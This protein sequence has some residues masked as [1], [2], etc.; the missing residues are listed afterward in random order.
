MCQDPHRRCR[1]VDLCG[2]RWAQRRPHRVPTPDPVGRS[3]P[4]SGR[5]AQGRGFGPPPHAL[6]STKLLPRP[7]PL[8]CPFSAIA[9]RKCY[10]DLESSTIRR[11]RTAT[12]CPRRFGGIQLVDDEQVDSTPAQRWCGDGPARS[13]PVHLTLRRP[14]RQEPRSRMWN[15]CRIPASRGVRRARPVPVGSERRRAA[16][17]VRRC[18]GQRLGSVRS[19]LCGRGV[20]RTAMAHRQARRARIPVLMPRPCR[21][22]GCARITGIA[23]PNPRPCRAACDGPR[24][25]P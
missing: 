6:Q 3:P 23:R 4:G 12:S 22:D 24:G 16:A 10:I 19:R 7:P 11:P 17:A 5:Q 13:C 1:G 25:R 20:H 18:R 9:P 21:S 8:N 15:A 14:A 2:R